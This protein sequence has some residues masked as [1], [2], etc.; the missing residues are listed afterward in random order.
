L[1]C[2]CHKDVLGSVCNTV[3]SFTLLQLYPPQSVLRY[4]LNRRLGGS[5]SRTGRYGKIEH[6]LIQRKL[7]PGTLSRPARNQSLHR[8]RYRGSS[9][10]CITHLNIINCA[11]GLIRCV[12][13][14]MKLKITVVIIT[15]ILMNVVGRIIAHIALNYGIML[16]S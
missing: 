13:K 4:T 14:G 12:H 16:L 15:T 1:F 6:F 7:E 9:L 5:Q 3:V 11:L 10:T 2:L 8:L